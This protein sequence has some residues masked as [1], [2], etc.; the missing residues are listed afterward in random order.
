MKVLGV[1]IAGGKSSRMG[2]DK[3]L[4]I[5]RGK[6]L[7]AH[8]AD[9]M[10]PQVDK[11]VINANDDRFERLSFLVAKAGTAAEIEIIPDRLE[12]ES[13]VAGLHAALTYAVEHGFQAVLSAP[14]DGPLLPGD[15]RR[16]LEGPCA[17]IAC[18]AGQ[19]HF[20]TGYWPVNSLP[21]TSRVRRVQDF[22]EATKARRVAW[23]VKGRD[24]FIN[25]NT[26]EDVARLSENP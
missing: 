26:P 13:P 6:A 2:Q 22:A 21:L 9:R 11:L 25:L 7:I 18:S 8:V 3:A 19:D 16:R 14:C 4:L 15:L 12:I 1:I 5:W 24:P 17:A 10:L 20:L 23:E